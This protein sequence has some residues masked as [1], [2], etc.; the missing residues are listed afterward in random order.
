M[1]LGNGKFEEGSEVSPKFAKERSRLASPSYWASDLLQ[2]SEL[3]AQGAVSRKRGSLVPESRRGTTH[4]LEKPGHFDG[5][6]NEERLLSPQLKPTI[7]L[8]DYVKLKRERDF[9]ADASELGD[10][11]RYHQ[12][13]PRSQI[14]SI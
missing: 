13:H 7:N 12:L 8:N 2:G 5:K 9:G 11:G 14:N 3:S 1:K 10:G 4:Q 6:M